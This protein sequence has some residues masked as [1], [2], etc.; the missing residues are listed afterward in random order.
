MSNLFKKSTIK[1][2]TVCVEHLLKKSVEKETPKKTPNWRSHDDNFMEKNSRDTIEPGSITFSGGWFGQGHTVR[3]L[4]RFKRELIR[5][6][7]L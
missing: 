7:S 4:F 3:I 5:E 2:A 1:E 6:P